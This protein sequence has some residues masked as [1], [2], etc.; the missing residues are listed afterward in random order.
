MATFI[1]PF[2]GSL[3]F[4]DYQSTGAGEEVTIVI[5]F[6]PHERLTIHSNGAV[7]VN[8]IMTFYFTFDDMRQSQCWL[9]ENFKNAADLITQRMPLHSEASRL[10]KLTWVI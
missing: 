4:W 9:V 1:P 3:I 2:E 6:Q 5:R 7:S 8:G 10:Y